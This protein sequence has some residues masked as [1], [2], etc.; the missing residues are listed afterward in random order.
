MVLLGKQLPAEQLHPVALAVHKLGIPVHKL[1]DPHL[2]V[3]HALGGQHLFKLGAN[4]GH[5]EFVFQFL[6]GIFRPAHIDFGQGVQNGVYLVDN[7]LA[8]AQLPLHAQVVQLTHGVS[9]FTLSYKF[10][11]LV[12]GL[13]FL[14]GNGV[15]FGAQGNIGVAL[16]VNGHRAGDL[17]EHGDDYV[18]LPVRVHIHVE[19]KGSL[20]LK[21]S[22]DLDLQGG[23]LSG[24]DLFAHREHGADIKSQTVAVFIAVMD[25]D[26]RRNRDI[27][28]HKFGPAASAGRGC[29]R[30]GRH[31]FNLRLADAHI[32]QLVLNARGLKGARR[33]NRRG[34]VCKAAVLQRGHHGRLQLLCFDIIKG[35]GRADKQSAGEILD[36]RLVY[37]FI[38]GGELV[39]LNA[40]HFGVDDRAVFR[41]PRKI[42]GVKRQQV[43]GVKLRRFRYAEG[44]P[45]NMVIAVDVHGAGGTNISGRQGVHLIGDGVG[46]KD[47]LVHVLLGQRFKLECPRHAHRCHAYVGDGIVLIQILCVVPLPRVHILVDA[48]DVARLQVGIKSRDIIR[49]R[50]RGYLHA[51]GRDLCGAVGIDRNVQDWHK[52]LICRTRY[53]E[54]IRVFVGILNKHHVGV[55]RDVV[56]LFLGKGQR[57]GAVALVLIREG[58]ALP[59]CHLVGAACTE[60]AV[61]INGE[62]AAAILSNDKVHRIRAVLGQQS[63]GSLNLLSRFTRSSDADFQIGF[64]IRQGKGVNVDLLRRIHRLVHGPQGHIP[65]NGFGLVKVGAV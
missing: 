60:T 21:V 53:I 43:A 38:G 28:N 18:H 30:L 36:I 48:H 11:K 2:A 24:A 3:L 65:C 63:D 59:Q 34:L 32:Q 45:R 20:L 15:G 62:A 44:R 4:V 61:R 5:V 35:D 50:I 54:I 51:S 12:K 9:V 22:T 10:D 14:L 26:R 52:L 33:Q 55:E 27:L 39:V 46:H 19:A 29:Q 17:L 49:D 1:L 7:V 40:C 13:S 41:K 16:D 57:H 6:K 8:A 31:S 25:K 64:L 47:N 42:I 58:Q 23:G 56:L 37:D